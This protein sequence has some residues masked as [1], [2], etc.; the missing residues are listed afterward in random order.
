M[1]AHSV[2]KLRGAGL[3]DG[4]PGFGS[5]F[6]YCGGDPIGSDVEG[7][8]NELEAIAG[9][10]Q[11]AAPIAEDLHHGGA[12]LQSKVTRIRVEKNRVEAAQAADH[13]GLRRHIFPP[14]SL[15][16]AAITAPARRSA[17]ARTTRFPSGVMR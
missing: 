8:A 17:S 13:G 9:A 12:V 7:K 3:R 10:Q 4:G 11:I 15:V 1:S 2:T 14:A 5:P 16:L 6:P